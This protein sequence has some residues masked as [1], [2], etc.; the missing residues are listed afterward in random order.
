MISSISASQGSFLN[1]R[2]FLVGDALV[3][4]Q[5]NTGQGTNLAALEAMTLV[6]MIVEHASGAS[7]NEAKF[8]AQQAWQQAATDW[9]QRMLEIADTQRLRSKT[10]AT[11]FL[12]TSNT[13]TQSQ[14]SF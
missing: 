5:P 3:H 13:G 9:S 8:L 1:G 2:A 7:G 10:F 11:D 12:G 14:A 4:C 6:E